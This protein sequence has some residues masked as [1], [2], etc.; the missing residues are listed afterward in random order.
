MKQPMN[1]AANSTVL[2]LLFCKHARLYRRYS[3]FNKL[4]QL[5]ASFKIFT[6]YALP[7]EH[8][9]AGIAAACKVPSRANDRLYPFRPPLQ[10]LLNQNLAHSFKRREIHNG[11]R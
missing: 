5:N 10:E 3:H 4:R 2:C 11:K 1:T 9:N 8:L 6:I 7:R